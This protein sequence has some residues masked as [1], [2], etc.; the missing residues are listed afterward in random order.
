[1]PKKSN[2][3]EAK[4][5]PVISDYEKTRAAINAPSSHF[6]LGGRKF[7]I[8]DLPYD[9]Y[10]QFVQYLTPFIDGFAA[11]LIGSKVG[12]S[13]PG[14]DLGPAITVSSVI[15]M[16]GKQ[17]PEMAQIVCRQ[18]DPAITVE[19]IKKLA[20]KPGALVAPVIK[21]LTANR[22]LEDFTTV[23]AQLTMILPTAK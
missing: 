20:G 16:C 18:T 2:T 12:F 14:V 22:I 4:P 10:L 6:E 7:N 23:F 8:V 13:I 21:Q 5:V 15:D 3:A 17:L 11:R 9:D 1:M 19:E